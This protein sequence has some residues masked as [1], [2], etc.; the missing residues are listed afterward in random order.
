MALL[1][2]SIPAILLGTAGIVFRAET[3]GEALQSLSQSVPPD[4]FVLGAA[5]TTLTL[6][7]LGLGVSCWLLGF[8]L[9]LQGRSES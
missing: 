9:L 4:T 2:L 1:V 7:L 6:G 3:A 5:G 8:G